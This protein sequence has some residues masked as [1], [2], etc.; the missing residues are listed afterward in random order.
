MPDS[1]V[2]LFPNNP[3]FCSFLSLYIFTPFPETRVCVY[4]CINCNAGYYQLQC[5]AL[6][7]TV[8]LC[9]NRLFNIAPM[10]KI[11]N[12][13]NYFACLLRNQIHNE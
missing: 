5:P 9:A 3:F 6:S 12:Y 2:Y 8:I 4:A 10:S 1:V 7:L 11:G 13:F